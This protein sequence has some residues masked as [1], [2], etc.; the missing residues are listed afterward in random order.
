MSEPRIRIAVE[1]AVA[2]IT[3]ARPEKLNAFD[4]AMLK[5]LADACDAVEADNAVR[6]AIRELA[7]ARLLTGVGE[8]AGLT[9]R[10]VM[11]RLG[12]AAS[13]ALPVVTSVVAPTAAQA[14]SC[15]PLG[16]QCTLS[17]QCCSGNCEDPQGICEPLPQ[18]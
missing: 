1:G 5:E 17:P 6:V 13:M 7:R 2:T 18:V 11:R 9:R 12:T 14:Q 3:V 15:L 8:P 16:A 4:I 10:D